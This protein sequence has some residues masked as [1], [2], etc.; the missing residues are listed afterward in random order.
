[1][2]T[3][4]NKNCMF[5]HEPGEEA[6]SFSRL[7]LSS[8][9]SGQRPSAGPSSSSAAPPPPAQ[10]PVAAAITHHTPQPVRSNSTQPAAVNENGEA[11]ALPPTVSWA[12][13]NPPTPAAR[14]A[15]PVH[16]QG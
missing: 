14:A 11:S 15:V 10:Q 16:A 9:N 12:S 3:C 5:L 13:K 2:E 7:D 6:D 1:N 8:F 4:P